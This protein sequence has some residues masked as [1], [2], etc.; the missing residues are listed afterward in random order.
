[1]VSMSAGGDDGFAKL[2]SSNGG[3]AGFS[4]RNLVDGTE[5]VCMTLPFSWIS[6]AVMAAAS[7]GGRNM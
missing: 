1:M 3:I 5:S 2:R 6:P 7:S 4:S